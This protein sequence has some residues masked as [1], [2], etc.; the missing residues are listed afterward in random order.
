MKLHASPLTVT[1]Q[2]RRLVLITSNSF[3]QIVPE[4]H[5]GPSCIKSAWSGTCR[6]LHWVMGG[7]QLISS[8]SKLSNKLYRSLRSTVMISCWI[9]GLTFHQDAQGM[10]GPIF[11]VFIYQCFMDAM[12]IPAGILHSAPNDLRLPPS[13][14]GTASLF[15][16]G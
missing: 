4:C 13:W 1:I 14:S 5:L 7:L 15:S 11:E 9:C 3:S 8:W 12:P 2:L 16:P 6:D 10:A